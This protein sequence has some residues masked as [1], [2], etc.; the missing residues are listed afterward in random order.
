MSGGGGSEQKPCGIGGG[1][2]VV[3][4]RPRYDASSDAMDGKR[5]GHVAPERFVVINDH[6]LGICSESQQSAFARWQRLSYRRLNFQ[7]WDIQA[8]RWRV[9]LVVIGRW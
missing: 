3:G 1:L 7:R 5:G 2:D 8:G 4:T 6:E 9:L